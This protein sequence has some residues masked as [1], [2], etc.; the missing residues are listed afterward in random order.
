MMLAGLAV[1]GQVIAYLLSAVLA[2]R[3]GVDGFEAYVVASAA[4]M[5]MV[6]VAPRGIEKYAL[7]VLPALLDRGE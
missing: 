6:T 3:L 7:R 4:F 2:R 1:A 5:L